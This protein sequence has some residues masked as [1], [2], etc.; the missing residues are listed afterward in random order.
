MSHW[1]LQLTLFICLVFAGI[2]VLAGVGI[3]TTP[4]ALREGGWLILLYLLI[5]S[6]ICFYTG[7]LLRRCLECESGVVTYPDIGQAAFGTTG[8]IIISVSLEIGNESVTAWLG[9]SKKNYHYWLGRS[10]CL[11]S[12]MKVCK[13]LQVFNNATNQ[14]GRQTREEFAAIS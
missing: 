1:I 11:S 8:R 10:N 9:R 13:E 12:I 5:F 4:Y 7:I 3:L 14:Q 6:I 2:N